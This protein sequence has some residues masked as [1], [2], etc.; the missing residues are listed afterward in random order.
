MLAFSSNR[1]GADLPRGWLPWTI[2][3]TKTPT[4]YELV[5]DDL[6]QEVVV[7][8]FAASAASGLK[9]RLSVD[10]AVR[11]TI[12]WRWRVTRLIDGADNTDRH[13]EDSPVRLLLFFDGDKRT[14]PAA[15][16][17][18]LELARLVS[19]SEPPYATLMYIWENRLPVGQVIPSNHTTR[20]QMVVAGS[21]GDRLGQWKDFERNYVEDFRRAFGEPPGRLIGIAILTDSD[22]TGRVVDAFYGDIALGQGA[23][24]SLR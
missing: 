13:A 23:S 4:Q 19:G 1:P 8:A 7:H 18:K 3:R 6:T 9:Q 2:A 16:Q 10:P 14:L 17:A 22:N 15:E 20:V 24:A 12:G 21:G 11:P 5:V